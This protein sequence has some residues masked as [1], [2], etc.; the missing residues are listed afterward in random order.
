MFQLHI[1][2]LQ[3]RSQVEYRPHSKLRHQLHQHLHWNWSLLRT[4]ISQ[5]SFSLW[6]PNLRPL[7][8]IQRIEINPFFVLGSVVVTLLNYL[9]FNM[10]V[11]KKIDWS[12]PIISESSWLKRPG[13]RERKLSVKLT[14]VYSSYWL[15]VLRWSLNSEQNRSD[16]RVMAVAFKYSV[17]SLVNDRYHLCCWRSYMI[18]AFSYLSYDKH[19]LTSCIITHFVNIDLWG[20]L[21]TRKSV[22][23]LSCKII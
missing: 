5:E 21:K 23:I 13:Q 11:E 15:I 7:S 10:K 16:G 14:V 12:Q 19:T 17:E 1:H 20:E 9:T 8:L 2:L 22:F 18:D 3:W 6:S 4:E